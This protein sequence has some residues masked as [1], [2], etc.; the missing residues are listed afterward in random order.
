MIFIIPN[1]SLISIFSKDKNIIYNNPWK[2]EINKTTKKIF[3]I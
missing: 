2:K 3:K 1:D